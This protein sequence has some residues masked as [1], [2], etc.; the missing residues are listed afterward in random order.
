MHSHG[1]CTYVV[2]ERVIITVSARYSTL[3]RVQY[4]T[5]FILVHNYTANSN[6][7]AM[8]IETPPITPTELPAINPSCNVGYN[9]TIILMHRMRRTCYTRDRHQK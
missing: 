2:K 8:A 5:S 9:M 1:K 4:C 3:R 7:T 6:S